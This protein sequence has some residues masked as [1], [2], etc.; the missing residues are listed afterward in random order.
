VK[1]TDPNGATG[2]FSFSHNVGANSDPTVTSPFSLSDGQTQQIL[3]VKP[4]ISR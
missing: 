2:N 1:Q 4:G 3:K